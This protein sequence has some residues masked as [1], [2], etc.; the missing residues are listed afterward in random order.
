MIVTLIFWVITFCLIII[1]Q[2]EEH[3]LFHNS[4]ILKYLGRILLISGT[5]L[6][7]WAFKLLGLKRALCLN[8]FKEDVPIVKKGLY[9][10]IKNPMDY[11]LWIALFGF[12]ILTRSIY[13][14]TIAVEFLIIMI[15]HIMLENKPLKK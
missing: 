7:L 9:K 3:P 15:P 13:N 6:F 11:G 12:G 5:I 4:V 10:Y 1:L 8:F 14:L 2:S